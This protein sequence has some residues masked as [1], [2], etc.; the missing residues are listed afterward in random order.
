MVQLREKTELNHVELNQTAAIMQS[1]VGE[2]K[3][4]TIVK[5]ST[6]NQTAQLPLQFSI[7]QETNES[8]RN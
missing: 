3:N 6:L 8:S 7:L 5:C 4:K 1:M 2:C